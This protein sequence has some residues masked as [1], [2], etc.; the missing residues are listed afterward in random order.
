M[1][2]KIIIPVLAFST[3]FLSACSFKDKTELKILN[4]IDNKIDTKLEKINQENNIQ[5]IKETDEQLMKDLDGTNET[6]LNFQFDQ[7]DKELKSTEPT[8]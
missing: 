6:I 5:T 2:Y 1:K 7:L 4:K 8:F 3:I